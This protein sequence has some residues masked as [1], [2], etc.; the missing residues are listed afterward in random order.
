MQY[1]CDECNEVNDVKYLTEKKVNGV[2]ITYIK[3]KRCHVKFTCFVTNNKVR[4]MIKEN[5]RLREQ[6]ILNAKDIETLTE[7]DEVIETKMTELKERYG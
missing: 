2:E 6:P 7:V 1:I 3:C 5:K 4:R